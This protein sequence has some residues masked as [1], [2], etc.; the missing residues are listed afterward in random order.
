MAPMMKRKFASTIDTT[1]TDLKSFA[2]TGS[3]AGAK[4]KAPAGRGTTH[5]ARL[6]A[7]C[8]YATPAFSHTL[9]AKASSLSPRDQRSVNEPASRCQ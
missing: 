5:A 4:R 2:E 8:R 7:S 9:L 3:P 6:N 1:L